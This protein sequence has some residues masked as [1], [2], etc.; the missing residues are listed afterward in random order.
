MLVRVLNASGASHK[1]RFNGQEY[2]FPADE[3][4]VVPVEA[5]QHIFGMGLS[6]RSKLIVRLGWAP[7]SVEWDLAMRRL[8]SF[9]FEPVAEDEPDEPKQ[10]IAT[11]IEQPS[12]APFD[13]D[14][15]ALKA[16]TRSVMEKAG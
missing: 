11:R 1:D 13:P 14:L 12:Q 10:E 3:T 2:V 9:M 8:D 7:T 15:I 16:R 4:V 5:A 6:D